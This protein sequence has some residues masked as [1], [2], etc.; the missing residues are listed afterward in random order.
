MTLKR[1]TLQEVALYAFA[2][3]QQDKR[4]PYY[5]K[6]L[7]NDSFAAH[8][9]VSTHDREQVV[10]WLVA[11]GFAIDSVSPSGWRI[12]FT[13]TVAQV[14]TAFNTQIRTYK[15]AQTG[16]A[17][18]ANATPPA[19]P[20]AFSEVI[21]GVFGLHDYVPQPTL[22]RAKNPSPLYECPNHECADNSNFL[23]P[24]DVATIYDTHSANFNGVGVTIGII[25]RCQPQTSPIQH[26]RNA[27][28]GGTNHTT[29]IN[30]APQAAACTDSDTSADEKGELYLDTEWAGS[31][32][33]NAN[34]VVYVS[35]DITVS[36]STAVDNAYADD[37]YGYGLSGQYTGWIKEGTWT[38]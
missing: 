16:K 30:I 20:Q 35:G 21:A 2:E 11:E 36:A 9:G 5:H 1:D 14:E 18:F 24:S 13:G 26:F 28:F 17:H 31:E 38:P 8:F 7:T 29:V 27:F 6:W 19:V 3:A 12:M 23:A 32:A 37:L 4:S 15:D 33:F 34:V 10:N 25:A 22:K